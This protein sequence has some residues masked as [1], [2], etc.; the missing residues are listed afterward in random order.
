MNTELFLNKANVYN[1]GRP[2]YADSA[3]EYIKTL[4]P[5][6]ATVA[7][8][9]AGT[10]KL[11]VALSK[12]FD[13]VF[14][15]E[16]NNDMR[17]E[18]EKTLSAYSNTKIINGT[19]ENTTVP[20]N[21]IDGIFAAQALHWFDPTAFKK[22]CR[23]I[24]IA[25]CIV[26]AVYNSQV[27]G[28]SVALKAQSTDAFFNNPIIKEFDNTLFY[29]KKKWLA[30][31]CSHSHSPLPNTPQY[32]THIKDMEEI[33]DRENINGLLQRKITTIVYSESLHSI[34]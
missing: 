9:G 32:L 6:G 8:I 1:I 23:R 29:T 24:G 21:S 5:S 34:L 15:I 19:A 25:D 33:F 26:A 14:A 7:D 13:S 22:E 4:L 12:Y 27:G 3:I 17:I 31:M 16:P 20:N 10:G 2:G 18:L 11:T 30:F 28:N